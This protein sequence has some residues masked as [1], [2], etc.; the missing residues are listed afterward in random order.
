V[1]KREVIGAHYGWSGWLAQRITAAIMLLYT[2]F[3][4]AVLVSMPAIDYDH[5]KALWSLPVMRFATMIFVLAIAYHAWVGVRNIFMDYVKDTGV[6]LILYVLVIIAL[7]I[8]AVWAAQILW[9]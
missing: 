2:L 1:V 5:W 9:G 6:R 8:Y 3:F 4:L 7:V